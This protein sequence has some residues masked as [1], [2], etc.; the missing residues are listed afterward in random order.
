MPVSRGELS[1]FPSP[2]STFLPMCPQIEATFK[3][4]W[5]TTAI[6]FLVENSD[7]IMSLRHWLLRESHLLMILNAATEDK[8]PGS[9]GS[10]ASAPSDSDHILHRRKRGGCP[11]LTSLLSKFPPAN[12]SE[13]ICAFQ[14]STVQ[15]TAWHHQTPSYVPRRYASQ[16]LR[17]L[18]L[19]VVHRCC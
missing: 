12:S 19:T 2:S 3:G 14:I 9:V 4:P 18:S 15:P 17:L 16:Y 6:L 8:S 13:N 5:D 10:P 7:F 11:P 1:G